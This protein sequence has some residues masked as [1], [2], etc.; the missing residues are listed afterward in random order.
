M[1]RERKME[2]ERVRE[3]CEVAKKDKE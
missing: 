2:R 3:Q 1:E